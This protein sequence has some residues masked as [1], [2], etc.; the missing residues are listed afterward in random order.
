VARQRTD[1]TSLRASSAAQA[2]QRNA[3]ASGA[4]PGA[5]ATT[6]GGV[7]TNEHGMVMPGIQY[8]PVTGKIVPAGTSPTT[9]TAPTPTGV[10]TGGA[11]R[12]EASAS[13][14]GVPYAPA[15]PA[16]GDIR[17]ADGRTE[18]E[19]TPE[20]ID[21][22]GVKTAF[23]NTMSWL[24]GVF[25]PDDESD[26][27]VLGANLSAV[28][29][30]WDAALTGLGMAADTAA[31][32]LSGA[33]LAANPNYWQN[34]DQGIE[35]NLW[36]DATRI[37]P[38]QAWGGLSGYLSTK[39]DLLGTVVSR[40]AAP[41]TPPI[42]NVYADNPNID[43][44][45]QQQM[46]EFKSQQ[47]VLNLN[48]PFGASIDMSAY[49]W[50][51]GAAD[52]GISLVADPANVLGL[53]A[54]KVAKFGRLRFLDKPIVTA[55]DTAKVVENL[56]DAHLLLDDVTTT[57]DPNTGVTRVVPIEDLDPAGVAAMGLPDEARF[58]WEVTARKPTKAA[59]AE[60]ARI[61]AIADP[62][63]KADAQAQFDAVDDLFTLDG[64]ATPKFEKRMRDS[65]IYNHRVI[66][67]ATNRDALTA[68]LFNAR[69]F[70]E[71][72][73]IIR[74]AA[75]DLSASAALNT[76]APHLYATILNGERQLVSRMIQVDPK[77]VAEQV[78]RWEGRYNTLVKRLDDLDDLRADPVEVQRLRDELDDVMDMWQH[79]QDATVPPVGLGPAPSADELD[80]LR[81]SIDTQLEGHE[82][83][84][85]SLQD[86]GGDVNAATLGSLTKAPKS[87]FVGDAGESFL[88][89]ALGR[90]SE[91]VSGRILSAVS[92][93]R[94]NRARRR[95][96]AQGRQGRLGAELRDTKGAIAKA[97]VI[98]KGF[99]HNW[100]VDEF[101]GIRPVAGLGVPL[102][103]IARVFRWMPNERQGFTLQTSGIGAQES[104]R[105]IRA[106]LNGVDIYSGKAKTVTVDGR[107]IEVGGL[108]AKE[109]MIQQYQNALLI[110]GEK[111]DMMIRR[112]VDEIEEQL[113]TDVAYWNG[114]DP[115]LLREV[116]YRQNRK[117]EKIEKQ[118][119]EEGYWVDEK[120][121]RNY[122]PYLESQLQNGMFLKNWREISKVA[123][124]FARKER[125]KGPAATTAAQA[126]YAA[127][128]LL[129]MTGR[130]LDG[131]DAAMQEFWRPAVLLR[132]GYM[133]R[134]VAEGLFRSTMFH[135]SLGPISDAYKQF[136]LSWNSKGPGT[137]AR[138]NK[139]QELALAGG[140]IDDMP[141]GFQRWHARQTVEADRQIETTRN[142]LGETRTGV[143]QTSEAYRVQRVADLNDQY[144]HVLDQTRQSR[145]ELASIA[146]QRNALL[147]REAELN[148]R[149]ANGQTL[150]AKA[151]KELDDMP[152]ALS[153]LTR[154]E[155]A[156]SGVISRNTDR[157][158][159]YSTEM[160][161][162]Q[163]MTG[164]LT[165]MTPAVQALMKDLDTIENIDLPFQMAVREGLDDMTTA[166]I[167][168]RRQTMAKRRT[169]GRD[170][171]VGDPDS[172]AAVIR[173]RALGDPFAPQDTFADIAWQNMS[174]DHTMRQ[175]ASM[176]M[177]AVSDSLALQETRY[178]VAVNPGDANYFDG[179]ATVLNQF[180][181]SEVGKIAIAGRAAGKGDQEIIDDVVRFLY[182]DGRGQEIAAFVNQANDIAFGGA[183]ESTSS[184]VNSAMRSAVERSKPL[185]DALDEAE[186]ALRLAHRDVT[187]VRMQQ[188]RPRWQG[189]APFA[190]TRRWAGDTFGDYDVAQ[191]GRGNW[192][193]TNSRSGAVVT[194]TNRGEA[195]RVARTMQ[196]QDDGYW[197]VGPFTT[198]SGETYGSLAEA[199]A[200]AAAARTARDS[201]R[202]A[203]DD[204][205]AKE[206]V[207]APRKGDDAKRLNTAELEDARMYAEEVLRR[208]DIVT[209]GNPELQG[210][211]AANRQMP[212]G[213]ANKP[214][215]AGDIVR[216]YLEGSEGLQP[217]IGNMAGFVGEASYLDMYRKAV[218]ASFKALGTIPED[219]FVRSQFYGRTFN[220]HARALY[221]NIAAQVGEEGVTLAHVNAIRNQSHRR[222][223]K[224]TK[225]WLYT[226]DRR[227][228]LGSAME[229][230]VPF[231]SA[232]QNSVTTVGKLAWRD[233][234]VI[235]AMQAIWRAPDKIFGDDDQNADTIA[236]PVG[237]LPK[238][239]RD[240]VGIGEEAIVN[241]RNLDLV[242]NGVFDPQGGP[243]IAVSASE[244]MKNG[245]FGVT[246]STPEW[247]RDTPGGDVIWGYM[248]DYALG[249][250]GGASE[251]F[252]SIDKV[253]APWQ[254]R[255]LDAWLMGPGSS[256]SFGRTYQSYML[257]E[258]KKFQTGERLTPPEHDEII[259]KARAAMTLRAIAN[260]SLFTAPKYDTEAQALAD[261]IRKHDELYYEDQARI[262]DLERQGVTDQEALRARVLPSEEVYGDLIVTAAYGMQG[263]RENAAGVKISAYGLEKARENA[264]VIAKVAPS[265]EETGNLDA[266]G[267]LTEDTSEW[268]SEGVVK[269]TDVA[270][271]PDYSQ[272][273]AGAFSSMK[274]PGTNETYRATEDPAR[275]DLEASNRV[276][277]RKWLVRKEA[278]ELEMRERGISSTTSREGALYGDLMEA[279]KADID[280]EHPGWYADYIEQ[281]GSR[282]NAT[283][284]VLTT[285]FTDPNFMKRNENDPFWNRSGP[286]YTYMAV[287]QSYI[288]EKRAIKDAAAAEGIISMQSKKAAPYAEALAS[289]QAQWNATQ[290]EL[291]RSPTWAAIQD[292]WMGDDLDPKDIGEDDELFMEEAS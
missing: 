200:A 108:A 21:E 273:A 223:L 20:Q 3:G 92:E 125:A 243:L 155:S 220:E 74:H 124:Q 48:L 206:S 191:A 113:L 199:Q 271:Q 209:N 140:T 136:E 93:S 94:L 41:F 196:G 166:A 99:A 51:T 84:I 169:Y 218:A 164:G 115:K 292:R 258:Q 210:W 104:G 14:S 168:Y 286:A 64:K 12:T 98:A 9:L 245:W 272:D 53:G 148:A 236:V 117:L 83:F 252:A 238:E 152:S 68:A 157:L 38:G 133:Q 60:Q 23:N 128:S 58:A 78:A 28:E 67:N 52:A 91:D 109:R 45:D 188:P 11:G 289:L 149:V 49:D 7:T 110:G 122:A 172:L 135:W 13:V 80:L 151:Q 216:A 54:S 287:R 163:A 123:T 269:R 102:A 201:A 55:Q 231:I 262:K 235:W 283:V 144:E 73:L 33:Y 239:L 42:G 112:L 95:S 254:K 25:N 44:A 34:R 225:D 111:G 229:R 248:R 59:E 50:Q 75:N 187:S 65:D 145:D 219:L 189:D 281:Q 270:R 22:H 46:A 114:I 265:L 77:L 139:P 267:I 146:E 70:D 261:E 284:R 233:P 234:S 8:D 129:R 181:N 126:E 15:T 204:F 285:A 180:Q 96:I 214:T 89:G 116:H 137:K 167:A 134:N 184:R 107:T 170:S 143:A 241:K 260:L 242:F 120:G 173:Q 87:G 30:V 86:A 228:N 161:D 290:F 76:Y 182:E 69:T 31:W 194:A 158:T 57:I 244:L 61:D 208:Y 224:D 202:T 26:L 138:A 227:T 2:A 103:P 226:I 253:L 142:L 177:K 119:R 118:I 40:V 18:T 127:T 274:I 251:Y 277:W 43:I 97:G 16:T 5:T 278:I 276:A 100:Q 275:T 121:S 195:R 19:M 230:F 259:G 192:T 268:Y 156:V 32:G 175:A 178:Y 203:V 211:L 37:S 160:A 282:T 81:R 106:M 130:T 131:L 207:P 56:D 280:R 198:K 17:G 153:G 24:S 212:I 6:T 47:E 263:T 257:S 35:G 186:T 185:Q 197:N 232:T 171:S 90:A 62:V 174:A 179:V 88:P 250:E 183:F 205:I 1:N 36:Q 79:A 291:R 256:A 255:L 105:E 222:A 63:A 132:L 190:G 165:D 237:F 159:D 221:D 150:G 217:V 29:S 240:A 147:A 215:A 141:K 71:A 10:S 247:L 101:Y 264:D 213:G 288:Q 193:I 246:P 266:I 66:E 85:R 162:L 279:V 249:K 4:K 82:R 27:H 154:R 39:N 176:R 72:A